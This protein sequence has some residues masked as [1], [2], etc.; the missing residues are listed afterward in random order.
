[1]SPAGRPACPVGRGVGGGRDSG[2]TECMKFEWLHLQ[3]AC[4]TLSFGEGRVRRLLSILYFAGLSLSS[5]AQSTTTPPDTSNNGEKK[6]VEILKSDELKFQDENGKKWTKLI[7][8]VELRQ[9]QV[10]MWCDSANI[11]KVYMV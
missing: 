6:E 5:F 10:L 11:D 4:I 1:M 9:G 2:S 7:G 8:N 3:A